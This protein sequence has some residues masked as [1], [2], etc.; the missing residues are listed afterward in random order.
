MWEQAHV[1]FGGTGKKRKGPCTKQCAWR[2]HGSS[3]T[4]LAGACPPKLRNTVKYRV[5]EMRPKWP[6][7]KHRAPKMRLVEAQ[8]AHRKHCYPE[9]P[10]GGHPT[11]RVSQWWQK[12]RR[13]PTKLKMQDHVRA[14]PPGLSWSFHRIFQ[15]FT[16]QHKGVGDAKGDRSSQKKTTWLLPKNDKTQPQNEIKVGWLQEGFTVEP[17]WHDSDAILRWNDS[18][19]GPKSELSELQPESQ[20]YS[21]MDPQNLNQIAPNRCLNRI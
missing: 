1:G 9:I 19:L 16:L 21:R 7:W 8:C 12:N 10:L 5:E 17:P 4:R 13:A 20:S 15:K 14:F 6:F 18:D 2:K 11:S 3:D